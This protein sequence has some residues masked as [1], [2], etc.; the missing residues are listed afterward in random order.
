M[1]LAD[2]IGVLRRGY[3]APEREVQRRRDL[4]T[5]LE[6]ES[7]NVSVEAWPA[8]AENAPDVFDVLGL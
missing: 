5:A 2:W 1:R 8:K 3:V 4:R 7:E 6:M